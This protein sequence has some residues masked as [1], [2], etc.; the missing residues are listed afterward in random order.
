MIYMFDLLDGVTD[1][2]YNCITTKVYYPE[3]IHN[4]TS[5]GKIHWQS[6]AKSM[7]KP[8]CSLLEGDTLSILTTFLQQQ[9]KK[10]KSSHTGTMF[11]S[12]KAD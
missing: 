6:L 5:V 4:K 8:S 9:K 11:L 10:K 3:S 2:T 1:S 12:K 7:H